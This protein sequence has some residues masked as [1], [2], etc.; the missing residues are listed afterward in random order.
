MTWVLHA[1]PCSP[2]P[3]PA[4]WPAGHQAQRSD[5]GPPRYSCA[6]P[7]TAGCTPAHRRTPQGGLHAHLHAAPPDVLAPSRLR[8]HA[9]LVRL[10]AAGPTPS[11]HAAAAGDGVV[12]AVLLAAQG[13]A[14]LPRPVPTKSGAAGG[15]AQLRFSQACNMSF[16]WWSVAQGEL[17]MVE[18]V[19]IWRD[20]SYVAIVAQYLPPL[21]PHPL[22]PPLT[23]HQLLPPLTPHPL[24]PPLTTHP[25][26]PPL[27]PHPLLPP[28]TPHPLL[29]PL[30]PHLL[31]PPLTPHL[32]QYPHL[33]M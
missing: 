15:E 17:S 14:A 19:W 3:Q 13:A 18:C 2:Q 21:T 12:D 28:L 31:L 11:V 20:S 6:P 25:L 16:Q 10:A 8:R 30:T 23:P 27:T 33:E 24:L 22:L 26:L 1:P 29:P 9:L 7:H 32:L 5:R 4:P